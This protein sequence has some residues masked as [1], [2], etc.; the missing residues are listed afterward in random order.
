[1]KLDLSGLWG[2]LLEFGGKLLDGLKWVVGF[3]YIKKAEQT[4]VEK[5]ALEEKAKTQKEQ[6][7]IAARPPSRWDAILERM[8]R[9]KR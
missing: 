3:F 1:M 8:R 9:G 6:L 4:K 5:D 7:D 2:P